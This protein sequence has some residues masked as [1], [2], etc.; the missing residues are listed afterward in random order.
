MATNLFP[1]KIKIG[2]YTYVIKEF[3]K[4]YTTDYGACVYAHQTIFLNRN[5][6]AQ[7]AA[8]TL[9]HEIM[10]AIWFVASVDFIPD[11]HEEIIIRTEATWLMSVLDNNKELMKFLMNPAKTWIPRFE[12][13]ALDGMTK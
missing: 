1:T 4:G 6:T 7:Q 12:K 2:H 10:H 11:L 13:D 9:L 8:E 5:Q 3:P